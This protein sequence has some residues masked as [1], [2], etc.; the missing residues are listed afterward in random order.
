[1]VDPE[2]AGI[3]AG[4]GAALPAALGGLGYVGRAA[5]ALVAPFTNSG[6]AGIVGKVLRQSA[7][8]PDAAV[9]ALRSVPDLVPGSLPTTAAAAGD[10]GLAGLQRTLGNRPGAFG[11]ELTD[12]AAAQNQ[13][14]TSLLEGLAGNPGKISAAEF[15]RDDATAALREAA[16]SR[17]GQVPAAPLLQ[18][19]D[20][21]LRNPANAGFFAKD[22]LN[23]VRRQIMENAAD[24][25]IHARA[26]YAIRKDVGDALGGRLQGESAN[27]RHAS[28]QLIQTRELIDDAIEGAANRVSPQTAVGPFNPAT[29]GTAAPTWRQYLSTYSAMSR[30]IDQMKVLADVLQRAQS[31]AMDTGGNLTLSAAKLNNILKREGDEL[32]KKLTPEQLQVLRNVQADLNAATLASTAGKAVGSNTVQNLASD[33]ALQ[34]LLGRVGTSTAARSLVGAL[35]KFPYARA[36]EQIEERLGHAM[37]NPLAARALMERA[38]RPSIMDR[39]R[40]EQA[41]ALAARAVPALTTGNR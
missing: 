12:R 23:R 7:A 15:A 13:A 5:G 19:I 31:G 33:Q 17:A 26:L 40:Q 32:A 10:V 30:P 14:R 36:G 27:L 1:L 25:T 22:A 24:G 35:L 28:S 4:V 29:S 9:A 37:L 21:L 3:G 39:L 18:G 34:G 8:D 41:A 16:L 38:A 11:A 6:Q 20:A 2:H